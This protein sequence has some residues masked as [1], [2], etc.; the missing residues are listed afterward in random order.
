MLAIER[1]GL[2]TGP[3]IAQHNAQPWARHS[4]RFDSPTSMCST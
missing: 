2:T 4:A 3:D 1:I